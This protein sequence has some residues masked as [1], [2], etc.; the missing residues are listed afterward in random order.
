MESFFGAR[1]PKEEGSKCD[2]RSSRCFDEYFCEAVL[3]RPMVQNMKI[4]KASKKRMKQKK[5]ANTKPPM[6]FRLAQE[7]GRETKTT[8]LMAEG[9]GRH[10]VGLHAASG[11]PRGT[12]F[13]QGKLPERELISI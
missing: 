2:K 3:Y 6:C 10:E 11:C 9:V 12:H 7:G 13:K 8:R 4:L 1:S 5:V